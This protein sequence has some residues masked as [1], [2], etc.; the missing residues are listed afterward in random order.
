MYERF[1]I[2]TET[3][4]KMIRG[5]FQRFVNAKI[6]AVLLSFKDVE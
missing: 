4:E 5:D 1:D 6:G 2:N 3:R